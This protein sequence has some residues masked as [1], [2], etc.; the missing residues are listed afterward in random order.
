LTLIL[1]PRAHYA[2]PSNRPL[3]LLLSVRSSTYQSAF[4]R[5]RPDTRGT[6]PASKG[7]LRPPQRRVCRFQARDNARHKIATS[8]VAVIM[9]MTLPLVFL[10]CSLAQPSSRCGKLR[11]NLKRAKGGPFY[12]RGCITFSRQVR[13]RMHV[14]AQNFGH[15]SCPSLTGRTRHTLIHGRKQNGA[16]LVRRLICSP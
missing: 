6:P 15:L 2:V 7:D 16:I 10:R 13:I 1:T 14:T 3:S 9:P 12:N 8:D 5:I 4:D 11:T